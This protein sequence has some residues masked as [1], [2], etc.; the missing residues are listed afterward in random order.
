MGL[1]GALPGAPEAEG[2]GLPGSPGTCGRSEGFPGKTRRK[3]GVLEGPEP[4]IGDGMAIPGGPPGMPDRPPAIMGGPPDIIGGIGGWG[5]RT[6]VFAFSI[7]SAV[8]PMA[9]AIRA[10]A[11]FH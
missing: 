9:R 5:S 6:R 8:G 3:E 7:S 2:A 11:G 10:A 1:A 4:S